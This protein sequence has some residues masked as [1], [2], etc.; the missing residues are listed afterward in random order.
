MRM[1]EFAYARLYADERHESRWDAGTLPLT[2]KD[3]AP[4]AAPLGVSAFQAAKGYVVIELP[5]GWGG[6][7]PHPSPSRQMLFCLSGSFT[8]MAS[9]GEARSFQAGDALLLEDTMGKGHVT[10]VTSTTPV[11]CVMI[12]LA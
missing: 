12:A 7:E 1:A 2:T 5:V 8:V 3:F 11:T 6:Q 9:T 4:P 10:E